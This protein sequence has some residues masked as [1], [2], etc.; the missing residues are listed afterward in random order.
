MVIWLFYMILSPNYNIWLDQI[1]W[2]LCY[3]PYKYNHTLQKLLQSSK[4]LINQIFIKG[5][6]VNYQLNIGK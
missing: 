3:L 6:V 1:F 5:V 4:L 2:S